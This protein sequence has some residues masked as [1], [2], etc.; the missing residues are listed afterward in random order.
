MSEKTFTC[1]CC[2]V[3]LELE[4]LVANDDLRDAL[5]AVYALCGDL[6]DAVIQYLGLFRPGKNRLTGSRQAKLL[7][8]LL[9]DMRAQRIERRGVVYDAPREAWI[10]AMQTMIE[11]RN[12]GR[13]ATPL[14][15]HGYLYDVIADWKP[16]A[17]VAMPTTNG[18]NPPPI[19]GKT[20]AGLAALDGLR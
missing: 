10:Y 14:K 17:P 11:M 7:N 8:E 12:A 4:V 13:L 5:L 20:G 19:T 3:P 6:G 16:S 1:P 9:P 15:S 18:G 2:G